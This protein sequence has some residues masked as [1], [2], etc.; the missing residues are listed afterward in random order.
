[1]GQCKVCSPGGEQLFRGTVTD[2]HGLMTAISEQIY[3]IQLLPEKYL[4]N[5]ILSRSLTNIVSLKDFID[6]A[7]V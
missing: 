5:R 1:M 7:K 2:Q 6:K 3:L 4:L